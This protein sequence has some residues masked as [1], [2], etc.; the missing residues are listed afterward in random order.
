MKR[1]KIISTY[2]MLV[3]LLLTITGCAPKHDSIIVE[4]DYV[5]GRFT[6]DDGKLMGSFTIDKPFLYAEFKSVEDLTNQILRNE[7]F[8][9]FSEAKDYISDKAKEL[10]SLYAMSG[11]GSGGYLKITTE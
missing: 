3:I 6:Y 9:S 5:N 4:G 11:G 1:H 2:F 8:S 10:N 7:V